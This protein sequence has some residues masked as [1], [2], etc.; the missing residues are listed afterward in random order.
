MPTPAEP[1]HAGCTQAPRVTASPSWQQGRC[2][3]HVSLP[4]EGGQSMIKRGALLG[5]A[6]CP[7]VASWPP[8]A[9]PEWGK[10]GTVIERDTPSSASCRALPVGSSGSPRCVHGLTHRELS[11]PVGAQPCTR[12]AAKGR[13]TPWAGGLP[14][15]CCVLLLPPSPPCLPALPAWR[16]PWQPLSSLQS[17]SLT[18][19]W[20]CMECPGAREAPGS[21]LV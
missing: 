10:Q 5:Q 21:V 14:P 11:D 18:A 6:R 1:G 17:R 7:W 13:C 8:A 20:W 2:R 3:S 15:H 4:A 12:L 9:G 16:R 19:W